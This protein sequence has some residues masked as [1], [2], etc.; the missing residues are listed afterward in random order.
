[1]SDASEL[2]AQQILNASVNKKNWG[3][4]LYNVK[5]F[6]AQGDGIYDDTQAV[7]DAIDTAIFNNATLVYFPPGEYAVTSLINTETINFVGDNASF[8]GYDGIITQLGT[9]VATVSIKD[10]GAKGDW[11]GVTGTDDTAAI[12]S[13]I[14]AVRDA[15]GGT[16]GVPMGRFYTTGVLTLY[17]DVILT[18]MVEGPFDTNYNPIGR[19]VGPTLLV[20]NVVSPFITVAGFNCGVINLIFAYPS[21]NPATSLTPVVYPPTIQQSAGGT[22]TGFKCKRNLFFNAYD[23]IRF[24]KPASGRTVFEDLNIGSFYSGIV[25]DQALDVVRLKNIQMTPFYDVDAGFP[26][27]LDLWSQSNGTGIT[28]YRADGMVMEDVFIFS[29]GVGVYFGESPDVALPARGSYGIA[30]NIHVDSSITGIQAKNNTFIGWNMV[31]VFIAASGGASATRTS[32]L[33][34]TGGLSEPS[35][36]IKGG[37]FWGAPLRHIDHNAG[38]LD[39][40]GINFSIDWTAVV[41]VKTLNAVKLSIRNSKFETGVKTITSLGA[42]TEI[43]LT[44]NDLNGNTLDFPASLVKPVVR[45]NRGYNPAGIQSAPTVPATNVAQANTFAFPVRVYV[46]S[47]TVTDIKINGSSVG[48]THG[49]FTVYPNETI[50]IV[51]T[52]VPTWVWFGI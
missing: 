1:M 19:D 27:N 22:G 12:Q 13:A 30:T 33:T 17:D 10:Y 34:E 6:G 28:V 32:I 47:G 45:G 18:G 50:T 11:D 21:Q 5:V 4:V 37:S 39:L 36:R 43:I 41:G 8:V 52:V 31:N 42:S 40:D 49:E 25:I 46:T 38:H 14:N 26:S 35:I 23:A 2:I 16:V 20:T 48:L 9:S 24:D 15:G 3:Q 7:Q 44:D 29:K 51:Y